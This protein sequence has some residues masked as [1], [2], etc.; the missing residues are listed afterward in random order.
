MIRIVFTLWWISGILS[1]LAWLFPVLIEIGL[2]LLVL[3]GLMLAFAPDVFIITSVLLLANVLVARLRGKRQLMAYSL[4]L[5]AFVAL[6]F[7][8]PWSLNR[9]LDQYW[10]SLP[11]DAPVSDAG[12]HRIALLFAP[13]RSDEGPPFTPGCH[14]LCKQLL[15]DHVAQAV[16]VGSPPAAG[17]QTSLDLQLPVTSYRIGHDPECSA[18]GA[19]DEIGNGA[20]LIARPAILAASDLV[21]VR[22]S[23][24]TGP[25]PQSAP[26]RFYAD[27]LPAERFGVYQISGGQC[28]LLMQRIRLRAEPFFTP[29]IIGIHNSYA[30]D[31]VRLAL[32]RWP[33]SMIAGDSP[34]DAQ[35]DDFLERNFKLNFG[36]PH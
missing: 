18:A 17:R 12:M 3:P 24:P 36:F 21:I 13:R 15:T 32:L 34:R 20:C 28:R 23:L 6:D 7:V 10:E 9:S 16:L 31:H 33:R 25:Y 30:M 2:F 1:L 22:D 35:I 11:G 26:W 14:Y 27:W 4:F 29:L 19:A 8:I 5:A